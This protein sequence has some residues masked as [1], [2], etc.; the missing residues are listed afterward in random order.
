MR[1]HLLKARTATHP[2]RVS[3]GALRALLFFAVA[4]VFSGVTA[5]AQ[6]RAS[7]QGT[8]TDTQ[9]GVI[10]G[11]KLTLTNL[12]TNETQERTSNDVGVYNFNALP[13]STSNWWSRRTASR[14]R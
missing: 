2:K 10:P 13:P 12:Q 14:P 6:Y 3:T 1:F 7:I 9:G 4:L 5:W 8:V 11:A